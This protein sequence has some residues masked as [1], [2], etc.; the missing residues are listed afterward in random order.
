MKHRVLARQRIRGTPFLKRDPEPHSSSNLRRKTETER[1]R[2]KEGGKGIISVAAATVADD[3]ALSGSLYASTFF[4]HA[5]RK[6]KLQSER[7]QRRCRLNIAALNRRGFDACSTLLPQKHDSLLTNPPI[8]S[9]SLQL[10][11]TKPF[12][13]SPKNKK[14]V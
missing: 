7:R 5:T 6:K 8:H 3:H 2:E 10:F 9:L 13:C 4:L 12:S 14:K 11:L 1:E